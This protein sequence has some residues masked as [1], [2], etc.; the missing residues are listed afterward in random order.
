MENHNFCWPFSIAMFNYQSVTPKEI[1]CESK[2]S[3]KSMASAWTTSRPGDRYIF[4]R[5]RIQAK[6]LQ[7][8][9]VA[10]FST[11]QPWAK[12]AAGFLYDQTSDLICCS[13]PFTSSFVLNSKILSANCSK[14]AGEIPETLLFVALYGLL[15][16][17][18]LRHHHKGLKSM[19]QSRGYLS[20]EIVSTLVSQ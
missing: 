13:L 8:G 6:A 2:H 9:V 5:R 12:G 17:T 3:N 7:L 19:N 1:I 16:A 14:L 4:D 15:Q 18:Q 10:D 20:T 11:Y